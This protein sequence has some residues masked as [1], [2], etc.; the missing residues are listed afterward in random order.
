MGE[1]SVRRET[2]KPPRDASLRR[3]G[4][5]TGWM[6]FP[7]QR[8]RNPPMKLD[9]NVL[10]YCVVLSLCVCVCVCVC[11]CP[12]VCVCVCPSVSLSFCEHACMNQCLRIAY[13]TFSET[14]DDT[15]EADSLYG[16]AT[17]L[18]TQ[19]TSPVAPSTLP[20]PV[21]RQ[22]PAYT[23]LTF[24]Q[25]ELGRGESSY[26]EILKRNVR[27]WKWSVAR[28]KDLG[29]TYGHPCVL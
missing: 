7:V 11:V 10:P 9:S 8:Y 13:R 18:D 16:S 24:T 21:A 23:S 1:I 6:F 14:I 3:W 5:D 2:A 26:G 12:C 20:T 19:A 28:E 17:D 22:P 25:E 27:L 4:L 29:I 15:E